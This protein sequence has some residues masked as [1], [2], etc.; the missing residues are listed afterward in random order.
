MLGIVK[1][2]ALGLDSLLRHFLN[3]SRTLTNTSKMGNNQT[4]AGVVSWGQADFGQLGLASEKLG[5]FSSG[6]GAAIGG[7]SF[8]GSMRSGGSGSMR[9]GGYGSAF[10][11]GMGSGR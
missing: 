8:G 10:G 7:G 2:K 3:L 5:S 1:P 9:S 11:G 6:G 4:K